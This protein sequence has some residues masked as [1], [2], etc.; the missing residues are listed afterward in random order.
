[1]LTGGSGLRVELEGA[2]AGL[3]SLSDRQ[4]PQ[5]VSLTSD[6]DLKPLQLRRS[7]HSEGDAGP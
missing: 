6:R 1:M 7:L 3:L 2:L 4:K 5:T